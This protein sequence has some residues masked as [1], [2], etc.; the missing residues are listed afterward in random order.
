MSE[1]KNVFISHVHEDDELLQ[2]LKKLLEK[3]GYQI[4]DSSIDTNNPN[5]AKN[6]DYIK[7]DILAPRIQWAGTMIVLISSKT[8][9]SEWVEWEI[10]YAQKKDKRI[11]G[12]W[13][14]GAQE[15]DLP[16]N[17]EKYADAVV[18][19]QAEGVMDAISGKT[20]NWYDSKGN[21]RPVRTI[22]RYN[23]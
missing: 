2:N 9:T 16:Q 7:S 10:E 18:G 12:V 17:L 1:T 4:R 8:H 6:E 15:S 11:V 23:C 19:W 13:A 22:D 3:N 21:E 20:N 14:Q 5:E